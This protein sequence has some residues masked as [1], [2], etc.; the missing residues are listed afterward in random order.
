MDTGLLRHGFV[1]LLLGLLGA[2]FIPVMTLPRLGLSA[3]MVGLTSGMLLLILALIW[4]RFSLGPGQRWLMRWC[5]I[6]S[7]YA[8][9][10]GCLLG[11]GFGAGRMTPVAAA[12]AQGGW[13]AELAV[14]ILLG[15]VGVLATLG[16]LLALWGLRDDRVH[17]ADR[18]PIRQPPQPPP[19]HGR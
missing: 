9:W 4:P 2:F 6:G 8:N 18:E 16:A 19:S 1:L 15:S 7:G 12:G 10:L 3:H 11:A 14:L 5:W 17:T 13:L